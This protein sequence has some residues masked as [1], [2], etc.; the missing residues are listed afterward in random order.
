MKHATFTQTTKF[1]NSDQCIAYE[2]PVKDPDINAAIVEVNGRYPDAGYAINQKCKEV[3][4][5]IKGQGKLVIKNKSPLQLNTQDVVFILPGEAYYWEGNLT[6]FIP[7]TPAW[8]PE[9][10]QIIK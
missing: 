1:A 2:Y 6:M 7:C 5:I 4:Y 8:Y 10:H 9:Q 3:A